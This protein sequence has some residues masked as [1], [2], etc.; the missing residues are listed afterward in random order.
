LQ[1]A[2][3]LSDST[4]VRFAALCH[5]LGKGKTP[6]EKWPSHHKHEQLGM[7]VIKKVCP[8]LRVPN[9]FRNLA[10]IT[11]YMHLHIHRAFELKTET[12][13]KALERLDAFRKP[14]RFEEFL[15][16]CIADIRGRTGYENCDCPQVDYFRK[17]QRLL[18][19]LH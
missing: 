15:L 1:Q 13:L 17:A 11:S 14:E 16:A 5:D 2:C 9:A 8:R 4:T 3:K 7:D 10:V 12:L 18:S 19:K 6:K